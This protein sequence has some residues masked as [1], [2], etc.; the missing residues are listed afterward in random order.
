MKVGQVNERTS[1]CFSKSRSN[2]TERHDRLRALSIGEVNLINL[3]FWN[4]FESC[5][6]LLR[7]FVV[8]SMKSSEKTGLK[9]L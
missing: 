2:T 8:L 7:E 6:F 1:I 4:Y 9:I 3:L 5:G